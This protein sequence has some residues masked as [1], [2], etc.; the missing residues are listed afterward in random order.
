MLL[1]RKAQVLELLAE[2]V[3][4]CDSVQVTVET[5]DAQSAK[6]GPK[7]NRRLSLFETVQ[8]VARDSHPLGKEHGRN[9]TA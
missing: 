9:P 1:T 5:Q 7:R 4:S 8:S 3:I 2:H 6:I